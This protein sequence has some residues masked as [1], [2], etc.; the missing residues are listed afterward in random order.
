MLEWWTKRSLPPSSGVMKPKPFSSLNHFT[1][2]VAMM[3]CSLR[4][5]VVLRNAEGADASTA[6]AGTALRPGSCPA[7]ESLRVDGS[8]SFCR[9]GPEHVDL[10]GPARR[11]D[12]RQHAGQR[13]QDREDDERHDREREHEAPVR[14]RRGPDNRED[15]P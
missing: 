13:G 4:E 8:R 1:V 10:R 14:E 15:D 5:V 2:P 11:R 9:H 6:N 12:G 7:P 3:L